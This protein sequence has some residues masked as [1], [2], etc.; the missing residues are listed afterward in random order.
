MG[1]CEDFAWFFGRVGGFGWHVSL[2]LA[3]LSGFMGFVVSWGVGFRLL[4]FFFFMAYPI[5]LKVAKANTKGF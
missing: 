1:G 5:T 3:A 2:Y 4:C